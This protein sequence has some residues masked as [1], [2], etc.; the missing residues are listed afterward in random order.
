MYNF[1]PDL[2][3][4]RTRGYT[5]RDTEKLRLLGAEFEKTN[6][7]GLITFHGPGQLVV[8]PII[9]LKHFQCG[10]LSKVFGDVINITWFFP[11]FSCLFSKV[12]SILFMIFYYYLC[13]IHLAINHVI[14]HSYNDKA[15][16]LW[17]LKKKWPQL[18]DHYRKFLNCDVLWMHATPNN[19]PKLSVRC[20]T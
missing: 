13:S 9:N 12:N 16:N 7:G 17:R 20:N 10:T 8:Y 18:K 2:P 1:V 15:S 19:E 5:I 11:I 14:C 3:G 6:R 4:L